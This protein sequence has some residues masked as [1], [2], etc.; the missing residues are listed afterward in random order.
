MTYSDDILSEIRERLIRDPEFDFKRQ[1]DHLR[2]GV[3]P[4]CGERE[5]FVDLKKPY[6][7]SCG[8]LNNCQWSATARELYP[9]IFDNLSRRHPATEE[10]PN[11]TAD[12]YMSE[13]RGF[14]LKKIKG[15]YTQGAVKHK[16]KREYY[17]SVKVIISQTCYWQRIIDADDVRRNG[18]KSKIVGDYRDFGWI[19]P[20]M[21]FKKGDE[22]WITEGIFKSMA[23]L[24]IG[25]KSISA[26][27]CSNFP[28]QIIREHA[29]KKITWVIAEDSDAAGR[30]AAAKYRDELLKMKQSCRVAFPAPGEDWD[31]AFRAGRLSQDYLSDSYW[32]GFHTLATSALE[33][34]FFHYCRWHSIHHVFDF[35]TGLWRCKVDQEK[36]TRD[37]NK[38]TYP[39]PEQGWNCAQGY[40]NDALGKF[41]NAAELKEICSCQVKLVYTENNIL[42]GEWTNTFQIKF[43]DNTPTKLINDEGTILKNADSFSTALLKHTSLEAF[44]GSNPDLEVLIREWK[45]R[46][47]KFVKAVPFMGYEAESR[48][49]VFPDFAYSAGVFEKVNEYGF[50]TFGR[51]SLKCSL[52]GLNIVKAPNEFSGD[53]INDFVDAFSLNGLVLLAWWTGTFFAEQIRKKQ[54]SW[55]FLEYTGAPGAGKSTQ[56]KFLWR[57]TGI[58]NYEGFDPNKTTVA[59]RARQMTQV[60]NLPVVLLEGDRSEN[61]ARKNLKAFD[62]NELKDMFNYGAT[63]RTM[64]VKNGG[65]ETLKL[66][67]RGGILISQ[68]AEVKSDR[69]VLSRIVHCHVTQDHFT[70]ENAKLADKLKAMTAK[71]LG[72]YLHAVLRKEKQL[73]ENFYREYDAVLKMF[74]ERN[75]ADGSV[76]EYRLRHCH[77]QV[78]AWIRTL[79]MLFPALDAATVKAGV[80]HCWARAQ[81]RQKRLSGDH[82]V[83][84][85][86]W[87]IYDYLHEGHSSDGHLTELLNH[88]GDASVIA[89]NL[90]HFQTVAAN[91]R[92]NLPPMSELPSLLKASRRHRFIGQKSVRSILFNKIV[93]CWVFEA[94]EEVRE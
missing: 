64:G 68:N 61:D 54:D 93:S 67:F 17:P 63:V 34:A 29:D 35:G 52:N 16:T 14:D 82:P 48:A 56:I 51:Q 77:A 44:R 20:G 18:A 21:E 28:R 80:E 81:S 43:G 87:E 73:L 69:A 70:T 65:N 88:S 38:F 55:T 79:P 78:A 89:I 76:P 30:E 3:C 40:I 91:A 5:C 50:V 41:A 8:R 47:R 13:V 26:L 53:F 24:S 84:E 46:G 10:N 1:G 9:E 83:V 86:F 74:E 22:I 57:L 39:R 31:D 6:R 58:E 66:I 23:L 12:A 92:Q 2:N 32:R 90:P 36:L 49:Y 7:V 33:K 75:R 85:Q 71:D 15:M 62:F 94:R 4:N 72:G 27:S 45:S 37:E 42:T 11:A 25:V 60:S 59:G 19:P